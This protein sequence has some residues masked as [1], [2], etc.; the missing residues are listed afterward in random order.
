M[1]GW[2]FLTVA[3]ALKRSPRECERRTSISRSYY[4][5]YNGITAFACAQ[6]IRLPKGP[7]G[8]EKLYYTLINSEHPDITDIADQLNTLRHQRKCADYDMQ[9][10]QDKVS[11]DAATLAHATA[12]HIRGRFLGIAEA[13][14]VRHMRKWWEDTRQLPRLQD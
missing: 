11:I 5:A 6:G 8:H 10:E 7:E 9:V 14:R 2:D 1:D 13:V 12:S 3:Q 4:A